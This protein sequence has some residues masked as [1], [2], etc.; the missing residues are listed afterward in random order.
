MA[1]DPADVMVRLRL[2]D[3][4][5][6]LNSKDEAIKE[7]TEVAKIHTTKGFYLKAIAVYKQILKLDE[8]SLEVHNKLADLYTK[9]RLIADAITEFSYIVNTYEKREGQTTPSI[10]SKRWSPSTLRTWGLS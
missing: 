2:G 6:K 10:S 5:A 3:L 9:Q 4:Y 1:I 7:Y 8:F